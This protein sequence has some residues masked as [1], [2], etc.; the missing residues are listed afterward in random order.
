MPAALLLC[1]TNKW[2]LISNVAFNSNTY[3][4]CDLSTHANITFVIKLSRRFH[5]ILKGLRIYASYND[6]LEKY[7][8]NVLIRKNLARLKLCLLS[9]LNFQ[10]TRFR[11]KLLELSMI[12]VVCK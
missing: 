3:F 6:I 12:K 10:F 4:H 2:Y 11:N 8:N 5:L 7:L 9:I 1:V